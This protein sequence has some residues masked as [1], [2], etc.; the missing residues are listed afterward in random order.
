MEEKKSKKEQ[1]REDLN[2]V[3]NDKGEYDLEKLR[4][5]HIKNVVEDYYNTRA[6]LNI[7]TEIT[8]TVILKAENNIKDEGEDDLSEKL[9]ALS[10][11]LYSASVIT[12]MKFNLH[13]NFSNL[14]GEL[15]EEPKV[16][17]TAKPA[18]FKLGNKDEKAKP[19]VK[20]PFEGLKVK[21]SKT[22]EEE[23]TA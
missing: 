15:Y 6:S 18:E 23:A 13:E 5:S 9:R 10:S 3:K 17:E 21:K 1:L 7:L 11:V 22:D 16:P 20:D 14:L 4:G 19:R 12:K 8:D 2:S